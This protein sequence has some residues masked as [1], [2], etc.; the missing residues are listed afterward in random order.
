MEL[1]VIL[2][3]GFRHFGTTF[4]RYDTQRQHGKTV[5]VVPLR[6]DLDRFRPSGSQKRIMRRNRDLTV[7]F[8]AAEVDGRKEL[9][10]AVHKQRFRENV[11]ESIYDF[12]SDRPAEVPC[13][14][15]EC[16]LFQG[17]RLLATGYFDIGQ[18]SVSSIY[19]FFDPS[20]ELG[21]RSLGLYV[22]LRQILYAREEG[23]AYL[24]HGYAYRE[25]SF[26]DYKKNFNG[27]EYFDWAGRWLPFEKAGPANAG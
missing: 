1:D 9:L 27:L 21:R 24:Y 20:P 23:K 17:D 22:L 13:A 15:R 26:Y 6:I 7:L 18:A 8:R 10:F 14:A 4:F 19:T 16:C 11:P 25:P 2:A 12:L 5:H 3:L